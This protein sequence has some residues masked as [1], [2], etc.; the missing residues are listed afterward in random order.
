MSIDP[1]IA[2]LF[3]TLIGATAG[4]A[5]TI[6][7]AV[8]TKRSEEKKHLRQLAFDAGIK[9][10]SWHGEIAKKEAEFGRSRPVDPLEAYILHCLVFSRIIEE[11]DLDRE[12]VLKKWREFDS[13]AQ[14]VHE[15]IRKN[16]KANQPPAPTAPSGRGSS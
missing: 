13:I 10:W 16:Q 8:V 11:G 1:V 12:T 14:A 4:V 5:G 6:A 15:E 7:V 2:T 9:T 3:G